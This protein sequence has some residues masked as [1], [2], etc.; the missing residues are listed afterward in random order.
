MSADQLAGQS[1]QEH[2]LNAILAARITRLHLPACLANVSLPVANLQMAEACIPEGD[3]VMGGDGEIH[4]GVVAMLADIAM[5]AAMR[6]HIDPG[7]RMA[8]TSLHLNLNGRPLRG[9]IRAPARFE[10]HLQGV[11]PGQ[12]RCS[13]RLHA[14]GTVLGSA[15]ATFMNPPAPGDAAL[16][17][18]EPFE[19]S[20]PRTREK[21]T[22]PLLAE[23]ARLL[24]FAEQCINEAKMDPSA[25]FLDR[26][27]ASTPERVTES[28]AS[29][30]LTSGLQ[31]ANRVGHVQGGVLFG[32]AGTYAKAL[33][34][35][36]GVLTAASAWF[37]RP[38]L[39]GDLGFRSRFMQNGRSM[40][41]IRTEVTN[42]ED[43]PVFSMVSSHA[44]PS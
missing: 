26:F 44:R 35:P 5:S 40:C 25:S 30:P 32:L 10:G 15:T 42:D 2:V 24:A 22:L 23:E 33:S 36:M 38:A 12:G 41:V 39:G 31:T 37:I 14:S 1:L 8:T 9:A 19:F 43:K 16:K 6:Q 3:H 28:E 18:I 4:L 20:F 13:A 21:R 7:L 11:N 34:G 29:G 27:W 17:P